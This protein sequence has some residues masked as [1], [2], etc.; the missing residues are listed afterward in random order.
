[1]GIASRVFTADVTVFQITGPKELS[2]AGV[3]SG[4]SITKSLL[5]IFT[6][7]RLNIDVETDSSQAARDIITYSGFGRNVFKSRGWSVDVTTVVDAA[8]DTATYGS[9]VADTLLY[10]ML[11]EDSGNA[12]ADEIG[13]G[14]FAL[15]L[16]VGGDTFTGF[17]YIT[18]AEY[19]IEDGPQ[20]QSCTITGYG[21]LTRA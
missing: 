5:A 4:A 21:P 1:M 9:E 19:R 15:E 3:L 18:S 6:D 12:L 10:L 20:M 2:S 11:D 14:L 7:A 16:A 17:G 8:A 13:K